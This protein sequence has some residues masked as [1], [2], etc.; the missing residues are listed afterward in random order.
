MQA[1]LVSLSLS[2]NAK[3]VVLVADDHKG[4]HDE[5][6]QATTRVTDN[7][8]SKLT[9]RWAAAETQAALR[10]RRPVKAWSSPSNGSRT[11]RT[12]VRGRGVQRSGSFDEQFHVFAAKSN[13]SRPQRRKSPMGPRRHKPALTNAAQPIR[14]ASGEIIRSPD[15]PPPMMAPQLCYPKTALPDRAHKRLASA[16]QAKCGLG[17]EGKNDDNDTTT[18]PMAPLEGCQESD[19]SSAASA[20]SSASVSSSSSSSSSKSMRPHGTSLKRSST[21]KMLP[22]LSDR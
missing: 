5:P 8:N 4:H 19:G 13:A 10:R 14:Q 1:Y 3:M 20:S 6:S 11:S 7:D 18:C 16:L 9:L 12:H 21:P 17:G 2:L 22:Y 15:L